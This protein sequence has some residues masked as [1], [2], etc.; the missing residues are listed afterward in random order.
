MIGQQANH[1]IPGRDAASR[2]R[3]ASL[4]PGRRPDLV[5]RLPEAERLVAGGELGRDL[6]AVLVA[7]AEQQL[8][9]ALRALAVAVLDGQ[10][11]LAP[12]GISADDNEDALPIVVEARREVDAVCPKVDVASGAEITPLPPLMLFLP[13]GHHRRPAGPPI[14]VRRNRGQQTAAG[15]RTVEAER[16]GASGPKSA[17]SA[18]SN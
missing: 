13:V 17:V 6:Q 4:L 14:H 11:F 16:P 1:P 15:R 10:Q 3:R 8:A 18:S 12:I 2:P 5:Q 9:P 7:Q